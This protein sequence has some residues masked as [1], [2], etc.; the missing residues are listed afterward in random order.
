MDEPLTV[1]ILVIV[2]I[3]VVFIGIQMDK[4]SCE[5][6]ASELGYKCQYSIWTD[7]LVIKDDGSKVLL[8]QL[9]DFD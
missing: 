2:T 6:T 5:R 4:Y 7:C 8:K 3:F 1:F 9:R